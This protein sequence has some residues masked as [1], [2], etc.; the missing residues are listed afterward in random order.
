MVPRRPAHATWLLIAAVLGIL[1]KLALRPAIVS[2]GVNDFGLAGVLPNFFWAAFL[3]LL[4]A[5]WMSPRNAFGTS[6]AANILYEL[7]QLIS[8]GMGDSVNSSHGRT[9]D[10]WDIVAAAAGA[11]ISYVIVRRSM[12]VSKEA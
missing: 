3:T 1:A 2:S 6:V 8:G 9:F 11:T 5:L 12:S 10:P 7:D 4:F